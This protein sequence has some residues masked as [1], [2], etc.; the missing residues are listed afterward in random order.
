MTVTTVLTVLGSNF[1]S[2]FLQDSESFQNNKKKRLDL[3][4]LHRILNSLSAHS[5]TNTFKIEVAV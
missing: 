3:K 2:S 4:L 1:G 5:D